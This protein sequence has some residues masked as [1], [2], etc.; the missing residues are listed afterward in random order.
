MLNHLSPEEKIRHW[1]LAGTAK[2]DLNTISASPTIIV[3]KSTARK[4][5]WKKIIYDLVRLISF[6]TITGKWKIL[7]CTMYVASS[8]ESCCSVIVH[9]GSTPYPLPQHR[10]NRY[11]ALCPAS[12]TFPRIGWFS[13][14]VFHVVSPH[15][16]WSWLW[17]PFSAT[18]FLKLQTTISCQYFNR[19]ALLWGDNFSRK[20]RNCNTITL[21]V[22]FFTTWHQ[23]V[24][25]LVYT[26]FTYHKSEN[27]I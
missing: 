25:K 1:F 18:F 24:Y 15:R 10:S 26:H 23:S 13:A 19:N 12:N 3:A 22:N 20:L 9:S 27:S 7:N 5:K 6:Q 14:S 17:K 16:L 4:L 2:R 8:Y 21:I 11:C